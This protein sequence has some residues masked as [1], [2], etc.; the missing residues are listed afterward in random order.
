LSLQTVTDT[1]DSD[2]S[3]IVVIVDNLEE[4][5]NKK[6]IRLATTSTVRSGGKRINAT[7]ENLSY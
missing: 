5:N 1:D 4:D 7:M 6:Q 3:D 2:L